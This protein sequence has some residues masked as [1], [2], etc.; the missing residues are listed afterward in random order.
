MIMMM[1]SE[2]VGMFPLDLLAIGASVGRVGVRVVRTWR[3]PSTKA[4]GRRLERHTGEV[5]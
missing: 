3:M 2:R 5:V 4:S 1:M